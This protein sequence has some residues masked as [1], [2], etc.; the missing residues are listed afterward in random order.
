MATIRQIPLLKYVRQLVINRPNLFD[1]HVHLPLARRPFDPDRDSIAGGQVPSSGCSRSGPSVPREPAGRS[2]Q[3]RPW[4]HL[5]PYRAY[6]SRWRTTTKQATFG[7]RERSMRGA[8]KT[9][10]QPQSLHRDVCIEQR[11]IKFFDG[12]RGYL[13]YYIYILLLSQGKYIRKR[14]GNYAGDENVTTG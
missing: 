11:S 8:A 12:V 10:P 2:A 13:S 1:A 5:E 6:S 9:P 4:K 14:K 3:H 7:R